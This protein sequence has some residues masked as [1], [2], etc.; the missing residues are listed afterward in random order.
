[1]LSRMRHD[2]TTRDYV[3]RRLSEGKT[4]G[5]VGRIL[6]RYI[7]REVYRHLPRPS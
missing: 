4:M 2:Q 7:A 1:M 3:A 5:E 6:K